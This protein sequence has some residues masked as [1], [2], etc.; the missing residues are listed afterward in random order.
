M[1]W[2]H[3]NLEKFIADNIGP[4]WVYGDLA[5]TI[6][7]EITRQYRQEPA[8]PLVHSIISGMSEVQDL[9]PEE[10]GIMV[11]YWRAEADII[12]WAEKGGAVVI[13]YPDI[14]DTQHTQD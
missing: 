8:G 4:A 9:T 14:I 11:A 3:E 13:S 5:E 6:D 2:T 1:N 7:R 12:I 10:L